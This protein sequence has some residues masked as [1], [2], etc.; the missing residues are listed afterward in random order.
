MF[1]FRVYFDVIGVSP[2]TVL[3]NESFPFNTSSEKTHRGYKYSR[4]VL[5]LHEYSQ[6]Y[7]VDTGTDQTNKKV[8]QSKQL[9]SHQV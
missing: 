3:C 4:K 5:S 6:S 2:I 1:F 8:H 7:H 9:T